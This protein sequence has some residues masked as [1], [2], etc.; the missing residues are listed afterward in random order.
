VKQAA[1]G[2]VIAALLAAALVSLQLQT[3]HDIVLGATD[4]TTSTALPGPTIVIP[5]PSVPPTTAAVA[6]PGYPLKGANGRPYGAPL[7][8][9]S[10][11]PVPE[12]LV[13]VLVAGSDARPGEDIRRTRADSLHILAV[14]PRTLT[15][16]VIGIPRDAW[17]EVPGRG[18]QK[19]NQ[20]LPLGGPRLLAD[21]VRHLTGLPIHFYVLTGFRGMTSMVDELGGVDIFVD[22]PM[23]DSAS[24]ARFAAGWHHFNGSEAL[25]YSRNRNNAPNGDFG[26]SENQG[27]LILAT[28]AKA[29]AE[30]EDDSGID[31]WLGV[32]FRHVDL[33]VGF[34]D[35]RTLAR[36]GRT[37]DPSAITNLVVPGRT[38]YASG[39]QSVVFL[40]DDAARIF[41]DL[42]ADA[43]IGV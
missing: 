42:R 21:T 15:G 38:G 41:L 11:V 32:L 2:G 16:S 24:G 10:D 14:N 39:G 27:K 26:R 25:A 43:T 12:D 29:R 40:G 19:I 3:G 1:L 23:N 28:L 36:F 4:G 13:F 33:D 20:A 34:D 7:V 35:V 17:V 30:I 37:L 5:P 8:F 31:R 6:R 22:R 18:Q 9:R